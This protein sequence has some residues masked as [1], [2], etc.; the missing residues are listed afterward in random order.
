MLDP[1]GTELPNIEAV[2]KYAL[3]A[4]RDTLSNEVKEGRLDLRYRIDVEDGAKEVVH[5]LPLG[6][7][8]VIIE[9]EGAPSEAVTV[10]A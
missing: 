6:R 1:E 7:A 4:A 9:P 10:A 8:I 5:S 3:R 2:K